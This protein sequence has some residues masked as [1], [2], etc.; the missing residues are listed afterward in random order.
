MIEKIGYKIGKLIARMHMA[1]VILRTI[2][3]TLSHMLGYTRRF[4]YF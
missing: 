2:Y 1:E 4:N 3:D